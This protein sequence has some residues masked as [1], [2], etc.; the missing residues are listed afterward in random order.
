MFLFATGLQRFDIIGAFPRAADVV[1]L[2]ESHIVL[3]P[4][5]RDHNGRPIMTFPNIGNLR[6]KLGR[7][8]YK[9]VLHYLASITR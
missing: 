1:N 6:E 7:E 3:L 4:G 2:L 9:R 5:G 8:D